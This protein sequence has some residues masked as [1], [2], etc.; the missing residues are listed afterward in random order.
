MDLLF[1]V[2]GRMQAV[3]IKSGTTLATDWLT[4]VRKWRDLA[5]KD[6]CPPIVV[7]GGSGDYERQGCR[8]VGWREFTAEK[9]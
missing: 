5:G 4:S 6:A 2:Q 7:F 1:E 8:V 3:E 9:L